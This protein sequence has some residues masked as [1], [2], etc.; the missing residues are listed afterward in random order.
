MSHIVHS[1]RK[2]FMGMY[3]YTVLG[4]SL[5]VIR[6]IV[7]SLFVTNDILHTHNHY[8]ACIHMYIHVLVH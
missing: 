7:G 1:I 2:R 3:N 5:N 4:H 8:M 6:D